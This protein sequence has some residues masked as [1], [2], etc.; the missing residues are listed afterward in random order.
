MAAGTAGMPLAPMPTAR[1]DFGFAV[2]NGF[3][4]AIGGDTNS[5]NDAAR[6]PCCTNIVEAYDPVANTW[7]MRT[8]MP[9]IR[10][11]FDASTVDGVIYAIA[12]SRD[13]QFTQ[14]G[15]LTQEWLAANNG[16]FSLTAVEAF[17]TS[18]IP[19]PRGVAATASGTQSFLSWNAVTGATSYNIYW[20]NRAGVST[21]ANSTKISNVTSPY[22]H[23]GLE[24]GAWYYYVVTAV[25]DLGESLPSGE[26]AVKP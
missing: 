11:D 6:T 9:T 1:D 25:T 24:P 3:V 2:L 10:D 12:G 17:S 4:Y 21:G 20:S 23:T 16:G 15:T 8:P 13:G 22:I 5:F 26:V 19:V 7:S 18:S 14:T